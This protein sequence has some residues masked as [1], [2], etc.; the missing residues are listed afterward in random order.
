MSWWQGTWDEAASSRAAESR[1]FWQSFSRRRTCWL[2]GMAAG[3]LTDH[4][5]YRK[6]LPPH[7]RNQTSLFVVSGNF[8]SRR[9]VTQASASL[10]EALDRGILGATVCFTSSPSLSAG[11][12]F[13]MNNELLNTM[14][15]PGVLCRRGEDQFSFQRVLSREYATC[16]PTSCRI[17]YLGPGN[18]DVPRHRSEA[19]ECHVHFS[20]RFLRFSS[21][22]SPCWLDS[23]CSISF[24]LRLR[25]A[26]LRNTE[27]VKYQSMFTLGA[28]AQFP[29]TIILGYWCKRTVFSRTHPRIRA[30][31]PCPS[32]RSTRP[33]TQAL[34]WVFISWVPSVWTQHHF[35]P[36]P[37]H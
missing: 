10:S 21:F 13:A 8:G 33:F 29:S 7:S 37:R 12:E 18:E 15:P 6:Q 22:A 4:F 35:V 19:V 26:S 5:R 11:G 34:T 14:G 32:T 1:R 2:R 28:R 24:T 25:S 31:C 3:L 36:V 20:L 23:M 16:K 9:P 30:R 27:R 17:L